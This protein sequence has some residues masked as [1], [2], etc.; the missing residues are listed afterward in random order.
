MAGHDLQDV[1]M[2][3]EQTRNATVENKALELASGRSFP[4]C[5]AESLCNDAWTAHSR[6][7]SWA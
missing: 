5:V 4:G 2:V 7:I 6:D 1:P 3:V